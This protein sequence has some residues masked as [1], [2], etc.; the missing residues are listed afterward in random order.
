MDWPSSNL[1]IL[2]G[3]V[4]TMTRIQWEDG[5][6]SALVNLCTKKK[7]A[8]P[9][10]WTVGFDFHQAE[11]SPGESAL[12]R[13]WKGAIVQLQGRCES[14][15]FK[16]RADVPAFNRHILKVQ[17]FKVVIASPEAY[18]APRTV[19]RHYRNAT[20]DTVQEHQHGQS[21]ELD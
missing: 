18:Q 1:L 14:L 12:K 19:L 11:I 10:G 20:K 9:N 21:S 17:A 16:P 15:S 5:S 4:T 7:V 8:T 13:I 6:V 3:K 2:I